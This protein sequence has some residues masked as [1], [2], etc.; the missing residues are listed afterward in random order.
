MEHAIGDSLVFALG[1]A[2]TSIPAAAIVSM[3]LQGGRPSRRVAFAA[4]W[5]GGVAAVTAALVAMSDGLGATESQ[6]V[7]PRWVPV[8][9]ILLGCVLLLLAV[10]DWRKRPRPGRPPHVPTWMRSLE[11]VTPVRSA[12]LALAMAALNPKTIFLAAAGGVA[13]AEAPVGV[14]GEVVAAA[15]FVVLS[16]SPVLVF[17]VLYRYLGARVKRGLDRLNSWMKVNNALVTAVLLLVIGVVL[18]GNGIAEL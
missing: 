4:G 17:L 12:S 2:L 5:V 11:R 10:K 13:I 9:Q 16:T 6:G 14:S 8:V 7:V 18:I 3:T 15:V 1:L